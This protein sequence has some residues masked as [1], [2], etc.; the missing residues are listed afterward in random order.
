MNIFAQHYDIIFG[1][2]YTELRNTPL[3]RA[4]HC[5]CIFLCE[6]CVQINRFSLIA[7]FTQGFTF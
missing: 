4:I 7:K 2:A 1:K 6:K 5:V 3:A